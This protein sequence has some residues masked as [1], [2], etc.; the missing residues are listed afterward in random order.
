MRAV[1]YEVL[2]PSGVALTAT[3]ICGSARVLLPFPGW[4]REDVLPVVLLHGFLGRGAADWKPLMAG[5]CGSWT[6][7]PGCE[8]F[9]VME[10]QGLLS[11]EA[12]AHATQAPRSTDK[13]QQEEES[14]FSME[15]A[16]AVVE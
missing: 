16:A 8:S 14:C 9:Q 10:V 13:Q 4:R 12:M 3:G 6:A 2:G 5:A 15:V 7:M 1:Q 11:H